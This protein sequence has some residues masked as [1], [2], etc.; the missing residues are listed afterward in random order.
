MCLVSL[1]VDRQQEVGF[2]LT[3]S[4][5]GLGEKLGTDLRIDQ[6][7]CCELYQ[8]PFFSGVVALLNPVD[9]YVKGCYTWTM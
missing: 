6:P 1:V 7:L 5:V 3:A 9:D 8:E 2:A 4:L